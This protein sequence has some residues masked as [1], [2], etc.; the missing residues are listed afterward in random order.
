MDEGQISDEE[1]LIESGN[2]SPENN[3]LLYEKAESSLC[4]IIIDKKIGNGFFCRLSNHMILVILYNDIMKIFLDNHDEIE[5]IFKNYSKKLNLK[6]K[7][8]FF[9]W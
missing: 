9:W 3:K 8:F 2:I 5:L 6:K 7:E 1:K 4:K